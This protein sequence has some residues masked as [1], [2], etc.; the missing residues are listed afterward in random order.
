MAG[1]L[2]IVRGDL[3]QLQCEAIAL[4]GDATSIGPRWINKHHKAPHVPDD[5]LPV[6]LAEKGRRLE[7]DIRCKKLDAPWRDIDMWRFR[8]FPQSSCR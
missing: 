1:H 2:F 5:L 7:A 8:K 3:L 4:T 6:T